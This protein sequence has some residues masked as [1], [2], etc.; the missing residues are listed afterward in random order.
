M[1][2]K[3]KLLIFMSLFVCM[4]PI[5]FAFADGEIN[6]D[7]MR[8]IKAFAALEDEK[9]IQIKSCDYFVLNLKLIGKEELAPVLKKMNSY[10]RDLKKKPISCNEK[11]SNL[12]EAKGKDRFLKTERVS[13]K[14]GQE[15]T[16]GQ[17]KNFKTIKTM[18]VKAGAVI[19]NPTLSTSVV[20][21]TGAVVATTVAAGGLALAVREFTKTSKS[22]ENEPISGGNPS[23]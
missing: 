13:Y 10:L 21:G 2:V 11:L 6:E 12:S 15:F 5:K 8:Q 20:G 1:R 23:L 3:S 17:L 18:Q 16:P 9:E 22:G 19:P 7:T 4:L 14:S